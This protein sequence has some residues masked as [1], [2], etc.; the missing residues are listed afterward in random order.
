MTGVEL[1]HSRQNHYTVHTSRKLALLITVVTTIPPFTTSPA[2]THS[3]L[4]KMS[5]FAVAP[6]YAVYHTDDEKQQEKE[7]KNTR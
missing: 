5:L 1:E 7:K 2:H 6:V 3:F 4:Y